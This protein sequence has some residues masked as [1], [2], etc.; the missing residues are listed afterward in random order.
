MLRDNATRT[1]WKI[2]VP[3][4]TVSGVSVKSVLANNVDIETGEKYTQF[5]P[6]GWVHAGSSH[7][8]NTMQAFF[9]STD[10]KSELTV[11]G[12]HIVVGAINH[13]KN[14][15]SYKASIVAQKLRKEVE[16]EDVVDIEPEDLPFHKNILDYITP[17]VTAN[18]KLYKIYNKKG[19]KL[20]SHQGAWLSGT[21]GGDDWLEMMGIRISTKSD[22]SDIVT[23]QGLVS[24]ATS[25]A[26][27]AII[28]DC[29][30]PLLIDEN[31]DPTPFFNSLDKTN[32]DLFDDPE[33]E[34]L[35]RNYCLR[36]RGCKS[37][38]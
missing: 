16:I 31:G 33:L 13:K 21:S 11:P 37:N 14:E 38:F 2:V 25:E 32:S 7:S 15:Y 24:K 36:R 20:N 26:A 4:Q 27:G 35:Y 28:K 19:P 17:V 22:S 29:S 30:T 10:D 6:E 18:K 3:K 12:L 5:P 8:H 9:S 1:K 23:P 34:E